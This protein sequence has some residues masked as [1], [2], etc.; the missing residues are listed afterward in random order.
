MRVGLVWVSSS[1][2]ENLVHLLNKICS[3]GKTNY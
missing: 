1:S 3:R 2:R